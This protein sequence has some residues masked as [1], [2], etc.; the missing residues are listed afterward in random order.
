MDRVHGILSRPK[1]QCKHHLRD[2]EG[3]MVVRVEGG[4]GGSER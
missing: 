4:M 2:E 3:V 1:N